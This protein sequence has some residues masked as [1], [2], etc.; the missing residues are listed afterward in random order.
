MVYCFVQVVI[1]MLDNGND[2]S[3]R[4]AINNHCMNYLYNIYGNINKNELIYDKWRVY[5]KN[6]INTTG[7]VK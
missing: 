3:K 4:I 2:T 1:G 5:E 7:K 6:N